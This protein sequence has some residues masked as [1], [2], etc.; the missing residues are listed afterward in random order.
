MV[1]THKIQGSAARGYAAYLTASAQRGDYYVG[2]E[3]EGEGGYWH[4]SPVAL[5]ELGLDPGRA[6]RRGELVAL[7]EGRSPRTGDPVRR[8]GGDGSRVA[9]I[10]VTFS[11]PKSVSA[12]WAVSS[13]YRRA[14]IEVAHRRAVASALARI[15]REVPVVRRREQRV[16]RQEPARSLV[17]AEFVHTSSRLTRDQE[18]DGVPDPQLHSHVLVLAAE[19]HDRSFAAVDSRELFRS[20]RVNGA[21]YRAALAYELG[22]LGVRAHGRTGRDGKYFEVAG[23]PSELV[24]RW[25]R[26]SEVIERAAREFRERYGRAPRG[27]ELG[28]LTVATRGTKTVA[29]EVD[30]SAAWRGVAEEY[31]LNKERA[32][33]LFGDRAIHEQRD[34]RADLLA[35]VTRER[36]MVEQR[37]LDARALELVAGSERPER[38]REHIDVL[39]RSGELVE[40]EGGLFTTREL[41]EL[42]RRTLATLADRTTDRVGVVT[43]QARETAV[44]H[45]QDRLGASLS[46]EQNEALEVVTGPGGVV[47]LLGEAGTGKGVV[48]GAAAEAWERDGYHV[49]G[50]AVAGAAAQRLSTDAGIGESMTA[51]SLLRRAQDGRLELDSRSVIVFDEAGMADSRRLAKVVETA[52]AADAKLVLAGDHAQLSSIGAGGLFSEVQERVPSAR[53][54]E[55]HRAN[56][57]WERQAWGDLRRGDAERA[58]AAYQAHYRLHLEDTRTD[59]GER[60]VSDWAATTKAHPAERVVMLTD[61][62][63]HELDRLN[64]QAQ[65]QRI[66]RGDLGQHQVELPDRPYGLRAGDEVLFSAQHRVSGERRVENGTRGNVL[67]VDDQAN[68]VLIGTEEPTP[69]QVNVE[70]SELDRLRLAYA[71]HVY[72]AQGMT[73]DRALV[74]TGGWQTDRE[75]A[76]VALSRAREQTHIYVARDELGHQ[77]IDNDRVGRL[78]ERISHSNAQ[79]TSITREPVGGERDALS[80]R[81]SESRLGREPGWYAQQLREIREQQVERSLDHDRGAGIDI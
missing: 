3:L 27:G 39:S 40:L 67:R 12:L 56:H 29:A 37:V 8:V 57:E 23:V 15:E 28:G 22:E 4:G 46:G 74:L 81:A 60:M 31:G 78:A 62:S 34:V 16:L 50:I 69:R 71:Q 11:A 68:R 80:E 44:E 64:Q 21:W 10:D 41:R 19:R 76:Y 58:L 32:N 20:A 5:G 38:A 77:G 55:V 75:R 1:S 49:I 70:Q 63:N 14:Q 2:G 51:D 53:L 61:A 42:E 9:G 43:E 36:S 25:S 52:R 66:D 6:V 17:A 30:V 26:R 35:D 13:S 18:R 59:A 7:M 72:K 45:A 79:E 33:A 47:T 65:Q 24:S 54:T 73:A 48:L